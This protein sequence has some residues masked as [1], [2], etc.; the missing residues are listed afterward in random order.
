MQC[1]GHRCSVEG[2]WVGRTREP[3]GPGVDLVRT[4]TKKIKS[5][6]DLIFFVRIIFV[7]DLERRYLTYVRTYVRTSICTYVRTYPAPAEECGAI[8]T[9]P[10]PKSARAISTSRRTYVAGGEAAAAKP[11]GGGP[12][13]GRSPPRDSFRI[14]EDSP[15][16]DDIFLKTF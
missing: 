13:G 16:S 6:R 5:L 9:S 10:R 4:E 14:F 7:K 8:S 2:T 11:L 12:R 1:G 15:L 3:A